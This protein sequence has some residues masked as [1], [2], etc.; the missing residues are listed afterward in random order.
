LTL[1]RHRGAAAGSTRRGRLVGLLAAALAAASIAGLA[2]LSGAL[3]SLER[4]TVSTRFSLRH[5]ARPTSIV[6]VTI[7]DQSFGKL[8]HTW[9]FPRS[10]HARVI[11]RL[12]AAGAKAI[13]YDV[14]FT[15]PTTPQQDTALYNAIAAAGGVTLATSESDAQGHTDVLGGDANLARA[16]ASAAAA[17]LTTSSGGVIT[18]YPY[19]VSNL[20]SLAVVAAERAGAKPLTPAQFQG[21]DA[22]IDYRGGVG[23][24][25]EIPFWKVLR[26]QIPANVFRGKIVVVG[27][28]APSLQDLHATPTSGS[29]LMPGP[30]VQANAIW[31]AL[32]GNPLK[33]APGWLTVLAILLA[34]LTAPLIALRLNV[35][36]ASLA[37]IGTAAAYVVATQM[38]FNHGTVLAVTAPLLALALGS[39]GMLAA[40]YFTANTERRVLGWTVRRRTEQ[41]RDAQLEI[42][43]RLVHAAEARDHDTGDHINRIGYLCERLALQIGFDQTKATM[44]RHASAM[45]DVGKIGIP[46][47]VLLKPGALDADEWTVMKSHA[48]KGAEI[49]VGSES[50]LIQMAE[51]IARTHHE[52]WDGTGYPHGLKGDEIPLVGRI[53]AI[54]DVFDA[55]GSKRPYKEA[56]PPRHALAEI[57]NGGGTHFDP[58][59]VAAFLAIAPDLKRHPEFTHIDVV[60]LESLPP[61]REHA[62]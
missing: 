54:C 56:W 37:A 55:L 2:D 21:G 58:A 44:L 28:T 23:T 42:I 8:E 52:R 7:D 6:V 46:D 60:D 25:K 3:D 26:G 43:T 22:L 14:Q 18:R 53:C 59:L 50:P 11:S 19:A 29:D 45:H 1:F 34:A 41:L 36:G 9:P 27:A 61:L 15:E 12:H 51:T 10:Y 38:A 20:R 62:A 31:S 47:S 24:F 16:H 35:L 13:V 33:D 39:A 32:H 57:A 49:L 17:N 48:L 5:L 30:E 40:N 4:T